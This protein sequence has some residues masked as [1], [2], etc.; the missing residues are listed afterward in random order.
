LPVAY[1]YIRFSTPEQI[2]GDSLRRQ[3][4]SSQAYVDENGLTLDTTLHFRDLGLSAF[5]KSNITR[6]ALGGFL[7]AAKLGR[8]PRGSFL[9]VESL[10]RLSRAEVL[11]AL[12]LFTGILRHGIT[13]VTL[14]D[15]MVYSQDSLRDNI[16]SLIISIT[17]MARAHE[18][19]V[20]KSRRLKAAWGNK[21]AKISEKKLT[22]RCP[23]WM[24]LSDD[25]TKFQFVPERAEI[26]KKILALSKNGMGQAL[27]CKTLNEQSIPTFTLSRK[28]WHASSIDKI[29]SSRALCGEF[30][31]HVHVGGKI[32][33]EGEPVL[34]YYPALISKDEYLLL[35]TIRHARQMGGGKARKGSDVPNL[36]SGIV[37]C[38]YCGGSMV[39][40]GSPKKRD[41]LAS[42]P[43]IRKYLVC[44]G[45]RRGLGCY[46]IQW[47]Y[48]AFEESFLTFCRGLDLE[49]LLH[50]VQASK[51]GVSEKLTLTERITAQNAEIG[52]LQH[53]LTRLMDALELGDTPVTVLTRIR[54]LELELISKTEELSDSTKKLKIAEITA[55]LHVREMDDI[56]ELVGRLNDL[57]STEKFTFRVALAE[58]LRH[59]VER[60]ELFPT[61]SLHKQEEVDKLREDLLRSGFSKKRVGKYLEHYKTE[62]KRQGRGPRG[63]YG[64]LID[65]GR[66]YTIK[67]RNGGFRAIYP[68][69]DDPGK[70]VIEAAARTSM[71]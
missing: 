37:K 30:Q 39:L 13:I 28:G 6:G 66:F 17:I 11:D 23:M 54:A 1:S 65:Q 44:D 49:N 15:R 55:Q 61:G 16:G 33:P 50:E 64:P 40:L 43:R 45:G 32:I 56:R 27:I 18:E 70:I 63:R 21:R 5:D 26:V 35:Q 3:T 71:V 62:P 29:L 9:L 12:E 58:R 42:P 4:E 25:K 59:V 22:A 52:E 67:G 8:I 57:D 20:T 51:N 14:A 31:M 24:R 53:R 47:E 10:D 41:S 60:L 36:F 19:S 38:G 34:D 2:K 46:A 68:D 69:Y 48:K 7:E